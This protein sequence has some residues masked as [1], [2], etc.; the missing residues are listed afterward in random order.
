LRR[1]LEIAIVDFPPIDDEET[2]ENR[3]DIVKSLVDAD[4]EKCVLN[5]IIGPKLVDKT[6][7]RN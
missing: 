6:R 4:E 3:G 2:I 7:N 1:D 5:V